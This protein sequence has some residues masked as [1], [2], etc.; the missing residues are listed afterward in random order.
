M[1]TD[2]NKKILIYADWKEL[3]GM[4]LMGILNTQ[5][6]RGKEVFSFEYAADWLN[7]DNAQN[8]DPNLQLY[9]GKQFAPDDKPN[10]GLFLDSSPDRWGRMLM[11]RREAAV[12]KKEKRP[13]RTLYESDYLLGVFDRHR[14]GGLRFKLDEQGDFLNN[15][16]EFATPPWASLHELEYASMQVEKDDAADDPEY[17]KWLSM[18]IAPGSSLGGARPKASIVDEKN[19]LWI[20]KF[21]SIADEKDSGAWEMVL[22]EMAVKA[23]IK[24]PGAMLMRFTG[25]HHTYLSKRFDRA[26]KEKRIHF[27]SAMTLLGYNDG[28]S[29]EQGISYLELVEFIQRNSPESKNDLEELWRRIVF[30][31]LVSNTDDHLRNHGCI[32]T[33]AGWRLSPAY[34][35]NPDPYGTGLSLNISETDNALDTDVAMSVARY[36]KLNVKEAESILGQIQ[37]AVKE[38]RV[39]AKT[40]GINKDEIE[41]MKNAFRA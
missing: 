5:R 26:V 9:Q 41:G 25:K 33:P 8:L 23:G 29:A 13:E 30:N 24:V 6:V 11:R 27:A 39:V 28:A 38:W 40:H 22:H 10:F 2:Y 15:Q 32:L 17:L 18:L 31:I 7:S 36:F 16:K 21:P 35:M 20:A 37:K 14:L 4:K 19:N 12:A 3:D 34:D 1:A